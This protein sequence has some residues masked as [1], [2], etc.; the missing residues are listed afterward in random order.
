[1]AE[2][3][4][5]KFAKLQEQ[6]RS[7]LSQV[8]IEQLL[9]ILQENAK[10]LGRHEA[11]SRHERD[12]DIEVPLIRIAA[13]EEIIRERLKEPSS[14][15]LPEVGDEIE[16]ILTVKGEE[17]KIQAQIYKINGDNAFVGY[18]DENQTAM[19]EFSKLKLIKKGR[20]TSEKT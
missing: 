8:P 9:A 12:F 4:F 14:Y 13:I 11:E 15:F 1:M 18:F 2:T 19:V 3:P 10:E 20:R 17:R 7:A 5:D 16:T 6:V